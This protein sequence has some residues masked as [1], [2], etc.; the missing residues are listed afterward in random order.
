[1][2]SAIACYKWHIVIYRALVRREYKKLTS[3]SA[4]EKNLLHITMSKLEIYGQ[5]NITQEE[6][7]AAGTLDKISI[8]CPVINPSNQKLHFNPMISLLNGIE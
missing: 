8:C 2:L 6:K 4:N 3:D 1:M 5:T 7:M